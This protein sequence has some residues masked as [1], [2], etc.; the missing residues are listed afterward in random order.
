[1]SGADRKTDLFFGLFLFIYFD[2]RQCIKGC[3]KE[4]DE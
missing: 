1:M 3:L 4:N 2:E